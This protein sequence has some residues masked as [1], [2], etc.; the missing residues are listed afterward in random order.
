MCVGR[1]RK[2]S[3]TCFDFRLDTSRCLPLSLFSLSFFFFFGVSEK[4]REWCEH[5][6]T[7]IPTTTSRTRALQGPAS[8]LTC[9]HFALNGLRVPAPRSVHPEGVDNHAASNTLSP[10][11]KKKIH[12]THPHPCTQKYAAAGMSLSKKNGGMQDI[13]QEAADLKVCCVCV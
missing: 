8:P 2:R 7:H 11:P 9:T 10:S 12:T 1:T 4:R 13:A 3:A 6:M 5:N